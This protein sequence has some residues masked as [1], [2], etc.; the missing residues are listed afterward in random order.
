MS[1]LEALT[2]FKALAKILLIFRARLQSF[3]EVNKFLLGP[4][5]SRRPPNAEIEFTA[6][7]LE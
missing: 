6:F 5:S 4:P 7:T 1:A 3:K 2:E